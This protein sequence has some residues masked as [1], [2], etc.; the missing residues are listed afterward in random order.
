MTETHYFR[1]RVDQMVAGMSDTAVLAVEAPDKQTAIER[2]CEPKYS[3]KNPYGNG[4]YYAF[5]DQVWQDSGAD[6][7]GRRPACGPVHYLGTHDEIVPEG[8]ATLLSEMEGER[9]TAE[10][11]T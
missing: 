10:D 5:T 1:C 11:V 4:D 8:G 2:Y 6:I 3:G 9:V 7:D